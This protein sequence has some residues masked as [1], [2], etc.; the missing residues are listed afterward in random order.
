MFITVINECLEVI[1]IQMRAIR[2]RTEKYLSA[3]L[4]ICPR[5]SR[6]FWKFTSSLRVSLFLLSETCLRVIKDSSKQ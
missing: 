6:V 2:Q 5:I 1:L 3:A 4:V